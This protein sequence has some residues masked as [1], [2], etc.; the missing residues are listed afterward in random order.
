MYILVEKMFILLSHLNSYI[1]RLLSDEFNMAAKLIGNSLMKG[2]S[3]QTLLCTLRQ[4]FE[5]R[6]V[7]FGLNKFVN[8]STRTF[9]I[10]RFL[11]LFIFS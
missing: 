1:K 6:T 3:S 11:T 7:S 5:W 10:Q 2:Q 9:L 8:S 4:Q